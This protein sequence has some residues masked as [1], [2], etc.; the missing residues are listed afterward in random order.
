VPF[1]K[2]AERYSS[3]LGGHAD[4]LYEQLGD[5]KSFLDGKQMRPILIFSEA[6]FPAFGAVPASFELGHPI[7]FSQ[8]PL[9]RDE[10][11]HRPRPRVKSGVRRAGQSGGHRRLQGVA[12]GPVPLMKKSF[13]RRGRRG[14]VHETGA[15][16][17]DEVRAEEM[18]QMTGG[19]RFSRA[20]PYVVPGVAG[21]VNLYYR[22]L[23]F[24]V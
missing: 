5:V 6:R 17:H 16:N 4:L 7:R 2:P 10:G 23:P 15:G 12:Q 24:S 1:P 20:L 18:T 22:R 11:R 14:G 3:V 19:A 13:I 9:D 21:S 8:I